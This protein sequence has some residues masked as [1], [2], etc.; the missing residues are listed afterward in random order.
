ML[1]ATDASPCRVTE[2][3]MPTL[4]TPLLAVY[5]DRQIERRNAAAGKLYIHAICVRHCMQMS[6]IIYYKLLFS[7]ISLSVPPCWVVGYS[8]RSQQGFSRRLHSL[9]RRV[10][11]VFTHSAITPSNINRFGWNLDNS[12][13]IVGGWPGQI[14][15]TIRAV[16]TVWEAGESC[17]CCPVNN[18]PF[19][20]FSVGQISLNLNT[21]RRSV[22]R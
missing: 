10:L 12:E 19:L 20:R 9:L 4:S 11:A 16:L 18:A 17:F 7:Y 2:S 14:L 8:A 21:I 6:D 13:Y 5:S 22:S 3:L 1:V 15:G